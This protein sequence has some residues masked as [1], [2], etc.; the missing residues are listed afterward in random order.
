MSDRNREAS[1]KKCGW[2]STQTLAAAEDICNAVVFLASDES[3]FING[4]ELTV[5]GGQNQM[6]AGDN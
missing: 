4:I 2:I 1:F 5:D 6:Y 3:S